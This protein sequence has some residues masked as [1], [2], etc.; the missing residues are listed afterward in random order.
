M[1]AR[2]RGLALLVRLPSLWWDHF[3]VNRRAGN[4]V[5]RA[6]IATRATKLVWLASRGS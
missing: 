2:R 5:L 4:I 1:P 3:Q 6:I